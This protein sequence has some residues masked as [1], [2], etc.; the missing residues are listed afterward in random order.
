MCGRSK[1]PPLHVPPVPEMPDSTERPQPVL[2]TPWPRFW[3]VVFLALYLLA[4]GVRISLEREAIDDAYITFRQAER[5]WE[6]KGWTYND[7]DQPWAYPGEKAIATT[8]PLWTLMLAPLSGYLPGAGRILGVILDSFVPGILLLIALGSGL[9]LLPSLLAGLLYVLCPDVAL[10]APSGMEIPLFHLLFTATVLFQQRGR[11]WLQVAAGALLCLVR[12][13]GL[14]AVL[15]CALSDRGV[16]GTRRRLA[17]TLVPFVLWTLFSSMYYNGGFLPTSL[18]GK[19]DTNFNGTVWDNGRFLEIVNYWGSLY[20]K[21]LHR[22]T[23]QNTPRAVVF[24]GLVLSAAVFLYRR[25]NSAW[26]LPAYSLIYTVIAQFVPVPLFSWYYCQQ[27]VG[28]CLGLVV[29]GFL[30]TQAIPKASLS[31]I[32]LGYTVCY[33][34]VALLMVGSLIALDSWPENKVSWLGRVLIDHEREKGHR[35]CIQGIRNDLHEH[36]PQGGQ[37]K[38]LVHDLGLIGYELPEAYMVD[39][40]AIATPHVAAFHRAH[41]D[42]LGLFRLSKAIIEDESPDYFVTMAKHGPIGQDEWDWVNMHYERIAA[43]EGNEWAL[44]YVAAYKKR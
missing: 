15:L 3:P 20:F 44:P 13:E 21:S 43:Y 31:V 11:R 5:L 23:I 14:L 27:S 39:V 9:G 41:P 30:L 25:R 8:T 12:H 29:G 33:L 38:V 26:V 37:Y 17:M 7:T 1:E 10:C 24:S 6:G 4:F 28:I 18:K 16:R 2:G 19:F 36:P 42:D 34:L 22:D 32:R 35:I 40:S